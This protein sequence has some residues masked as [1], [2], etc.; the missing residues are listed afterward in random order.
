MNTHLKS[1]RRLTFS[2][3]A[4]KPFSNRAFDNKSHNTLQIK[5]S[6]A[7]SPVHPLP[8]LYASFLNCVTVRENTS[9]HGIT[10]VWFHR[11]RKTFKEIH[12]LFV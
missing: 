1:R 11:Q 2:T 4:N 7:H 10:M 12:T 8:Q 6:L 3:A 5:I 9:Y